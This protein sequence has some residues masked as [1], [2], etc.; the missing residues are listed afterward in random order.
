[1]EGAIAVL[2]RRACRLLQREGSS[3][4]SR[5][6]PDSTLGW[7]SGHSRQVVSL[8]DMV[9]Y[10]EFTSRRSL[11]LRHTRQLDHNKIS[12]GSGSQAVNA[13]FGCLGIQQPCMDIRSLAD[14]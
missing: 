4:E 13:K 14:H 11:A 8:F 10:R 7:T 3:E 5:L 6:A 2:G 1:M 9:E 12:A